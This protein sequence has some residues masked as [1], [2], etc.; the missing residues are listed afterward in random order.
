MLSHRSHSSNGGSATLG[1]AIFGL[2]RGVGYTIAAY[3]DMTKIGDA[4]LLGVI[5]VIPRGAQIS[6]GP[7]VVDV[8]YGQVESVAWYL[9]R[10]PGGR[11]DLRRVRC[12]VCAALGGDASDLRVAVSRRDLSCRLRCQ[13]SAGAQ[14]GLDRGNLDGRR[15]GHTT[16]TSPPDSV[17]SDRSNIQI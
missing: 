11:Y 16:P 14:H 15:A 10:W 13:Q 9:V 1:F 7:S 2:F 6:A 3:N 4:I 12:R 8:G 17:L 5:A